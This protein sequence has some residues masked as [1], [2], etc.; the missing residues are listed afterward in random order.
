MYGTITRRVFIQGALAAST[1]L[2]SGP[3]VWVRRTAASWERGSPVHP[4][5]D[6]LRVV[7]V[8]DPSMTR[9]RETRCDWGRQEEL[10]VA[11]RVWEN[12]D[13]MACS[14]AGQ[15]HPRDAWGAIFI[16]PPGKAWS[17]TTVAI[18][19]NH[20]GRQHSRSAVISRLCHAFV[21]RGVR[22]S[23]I[24]IYDARHGEGMA[25]ETPFRGLP[26]GVRIEGRWTGMGKTTFLPPPWRKGKGKTRCLDP[27]V[28]G[29]VDI[30]VNVALCKGH[31]QRF[32]GFTM[33]MKNHLGTFSPR[34][35]HM[36]ESLLYLL[37]INQSKEVLGA[38]DP[39]NGR[40]L[41]PRQ[42]LCLVDGLWAS[43]CGPRCGSSHQPNFL[44]MGVLS[45]VVDYMVAT[46][47]RWKRMGWPVN[48]DALDQILNSFGFEGVR[49]SD[50]MQW[51]GT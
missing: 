6:P 38:L 43:R 27:L 8:E 21:E 9:A 10:V 3:F 49:D 11:Q 34:P 47:L 15:R 19:V 31:R 46:E 16:K 14:L 28:D 42:Q 13:R 50:G 39:K 36:K 23:N 24:H 37:S 1:A 41:F 32:G 35:A 33:T 5:I 26:S 12:M 22:P 18:K 4:H 44:A 29:S 30:L 25:Q 45:P 40:V 20:I 2:A 7:A 17:E 48:M 51:V